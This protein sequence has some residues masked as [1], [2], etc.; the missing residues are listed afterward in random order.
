MRRKKR[1]RS[2]DMARNNRGGERKKDGTMLKRGNDDPYKTR[3]K[4]FE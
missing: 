1:K 2:A 3:S 4:N